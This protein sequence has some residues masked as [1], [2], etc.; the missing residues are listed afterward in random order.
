ML[1]SSVETA[2]SPCYFLAGWQRDSI[3]EVFLPP[4]LGRVF[5]LVLSLVVALL[6]WPRRGR[7]VRAPVVGVV[8]VL[9]CCLFSFCSSFS[10]GLCRERP[11]RGP[12]FSRR[13]VLCWRAG[14]RPSGVAMWPGAALDLPSSFRGGLYSIRGGPR[15]VRFGSCGSVG[16]T[17]WHLN[18]LS[19]LLPP[20]FRRLC[21]QPSA[22]FDVPADPIDLL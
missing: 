5:C 11:G 16:R 21:G 4:P 22:P 20:L 19:P 10:G 8:V 18:L 9:F 14:Q 17:V 3:M 6:R 12:R 13:M 2:L 1:R 7:C 15:S